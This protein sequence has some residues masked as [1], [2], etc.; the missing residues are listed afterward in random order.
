MIT[1]TTEEKPKFQPTLLLCYE[2]AY[3]REFMAKALAIQKTGEQCR[4]ILD[5]T[6]FYPLGGGQPSDTGTIKGASGIAS[7][8]EVRVENGVV[9]HLGD[10]KGS[11]AEGEAV[12]GNVDWDRRYSLM[13]NH[14]LAHLM[15]EAI[16]RA[17]G[18]SG[19]VVGSGLDADKARLDIAA[20]TSLGS[21]LAEIQKVANS[22]I[23]ENRPVEI[24]IL[25]RNEAEKYVTRFHENLK[26][27]PTHVQSVRIIE[28]KDWHACACGGIHV[29]STG[30]IGEAEILRRMSKGKD[31]ERLEFRAKTS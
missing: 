14:T 5:Q 12:T 15:A 24:K 13:R 6:A 4:I 16:R 3:I 1:M 18:L 7:V 26:T 11:I 27:L 23:K 28:V 31:V 19:E 20:Q 8:K 22:V 29:R 9:M 2:D 21:F 30:E 25:Q 10:V 17:T